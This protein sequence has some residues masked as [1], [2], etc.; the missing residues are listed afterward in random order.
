[1]A[2]YLAM[3][4]AYLHLL[5]IERVTSSTRVA[6]DAAAVIAGTRGAAIVSALVI[7]SAIGVLNGV[8][9]AGPRMYSAMAQEGLAFPSLGAIHP[10]FQTPH[11]A[12]AA[13]ALWSSLLVATGTYRELFTRVIYTEW[14]FFALMAIGLF[15]LR[16][17]PGYVPVYS[18]PGY[19]VVPMLFIVASIV[20]AVIQIAA[21]PW[22]A[23]S[24]LLLV[25]L[26]LPVYYV[27]RRRAPQTFTAHA[28]H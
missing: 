7:L 5:P 3:N 17:R 22:H 4:A 6:S 19:P 15:R 12:I 14:L 24:G 8:I 21:D 23:A 28:D 9:L 25:V 18:A 2:V 27:W 10:R 26:G 20:V 16:R 11:L 13:Q 1:M